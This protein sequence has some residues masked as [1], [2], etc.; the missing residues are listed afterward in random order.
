M[1]PPKEHV[2]NNVRGDIAHKI[3][4]PVIG[5]T[6][7]KSYLEAAMTTESQTPMNT[8]TNNP[9]VTNSTTAHEKQ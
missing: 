8:D 9:R 1:S 6:P 7:R 4:T 3:Q 2:E 5:H